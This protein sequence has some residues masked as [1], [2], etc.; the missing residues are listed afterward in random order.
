[1]ATSPTPQ[2]AASQIALHTPR[3][4]LRPFADTDTTSVATL[5]ADERV[6]RFLA[7][8]RLSEAGA[9]RFA[10]E[11]VR[12][13]GDELREAGYATLAVRRR[14]DDRFLGYCGLR[15][16]PDRISA[17][18]LVFALAPPHWHRGYA[19]E[20]VGA[21]LHWAGTIAGLREVLSLV[22]PEHGR[23][24]AVMAAA[25]MRHAGQ[26]TRYYGESLSLYRLRLGEN[27][28]ADTAKA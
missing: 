8:G 4:L 23:S 7:I 6:T 18:E 26:T 10:A 14:E 24:R 16:L 19:R 22:R 12:Q 9:R 15:P 2:P 27:Q 25:G 11:F 13:S 17:A 28:P 20:A 1:M 21:V 5:F 3:L